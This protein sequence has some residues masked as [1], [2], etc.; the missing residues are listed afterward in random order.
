MP[1]LEV[2][3]VED[4]AAS[5]EL[6]QIALESTGTE[7]T[8][9]GDPQ[10][11]ALRITQQK[12]DGIFL[13]LRMPGLNGCDLTAMIRGSRWNRDT[14]VIIVSGAEREE[15]QR[16]FSLGATFY[17]QK[18][19]DFR[20]VVKLFRT[21]QG[22]MTRHSLRFLRAPLRTDVYCAMATKTM[23]CMSANV[24]VGGMLLEAEN[25][26]AALDRVVLEFRL[27]N[28]RQGTRTEGIVARVDE[29]GRA[30]LYFVGMTVDDGILI[31]DLVA[32]AG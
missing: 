14:P 16:A 7:V 1:S 24:S 18:P 22:A 21:T 19:F 27:P 4:D 32:R 8:A 6:L 5:L 28:A 29:Y 3:V 23:R 12:F 9:L 2:L 11:A 17:L 13:D 25:R 20:K 15:M 30:G 26:L 10:Q 31:R